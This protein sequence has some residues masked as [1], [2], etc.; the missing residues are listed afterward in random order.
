MACNIPEQLNHLATSLQILDP[1]ADLGVQSL[2]S[3]LL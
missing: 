3:Y 2:L 1:Q